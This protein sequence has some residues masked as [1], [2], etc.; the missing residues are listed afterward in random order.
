MKSF[1]NFITESPTEWAV[2]WQGHVLEHVFYGNMNAFL[3]IH[4]TI[5]K[6][7]FGHTEYSAFHLTSLEGL[8]R[9]LKIQNTSKTLSTF[10]VMHSEKIELKDV[11]YKIAGDE[12]EGLPDHNDLILEVSGRLLAGS[13]SDLMSKPDKRGIRGFD[14]TKEQCRDYTNLINKFKLDCIAEAFHKG[15]NPKDGGGNS[16]SSISMYAWFQGIERDHPQFLPKWYAKYYQIVLK[17]M[18]ENILEINEVFRTKFHKLEHRDGDYNEVLLSHVHV[19]N[20]MAI[21]SNYDYAILEHIVDECDKLGYDCEI[22]ETP[23]DIVN[24]IGEFTDRHYEG[25][26]SDWDDDDY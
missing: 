10:T 25:Y 12:V 5:I 4:P 1:K 16:L 20:M 23:S 21:N 15:I 8:K 7:V 22:G 9:I 2:A 18:R 6:K 3:L 13:H 14:V 24:F 19:T 17:Y 26:S 11:F